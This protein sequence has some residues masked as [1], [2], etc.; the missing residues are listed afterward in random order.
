[1]RTTWWSISSEF[2]IWTTDTS[3]S[4]SSKPRLYFCR[5]FLKRQRGVSVYFIIEIFVW[6]CIQYRLYLVPSFLEQVDWIWLQFLRRRACRHLC[7][8]HEVIG[9]T[10]EWK[11]YTILLQSEEQAFSS[12][13]YSLKICESSGDNGEK[14]C[15]DH[16]FDCLQNQWC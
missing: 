9:A 5:T 12:A 11:L 10:L 8:L 15:Q 4:S 3:I 2:S 13:G 1:M 6:L 14:R 7:F 16:K